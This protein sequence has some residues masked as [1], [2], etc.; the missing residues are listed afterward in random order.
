MLKIAVALSCM[1]APLPVMAFGPG[2]GSETVR[3][4]RLEQTGSFVKKTKVC[5]TEKEWRDFQ[6]KVK[7][8]L[9][10]MDDAAKVNASRPRT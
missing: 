8:D 9:R 7:R 6:A 2:S 10:A 3:C 1:L 4:K 5:H